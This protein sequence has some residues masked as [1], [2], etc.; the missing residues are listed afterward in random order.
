MLQLGLT[1]DFKRQVL[2]WDGTTVNIKEPSGLIGKYDLNKRE[3][4]EMREVFVQTTEPA[5]TR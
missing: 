1:D 2:Q 4:R 5:S 3:M